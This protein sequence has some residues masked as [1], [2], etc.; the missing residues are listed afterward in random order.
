MVFGLLVVEDH[1]AQLA[2][3]TETKAALKNRGRV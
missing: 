3:H 2:I 1:R